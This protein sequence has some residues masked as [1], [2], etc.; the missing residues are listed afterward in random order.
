MWRCVAC[1]TTKRQQ[2]TKLAS[3]TV[4][5]NLVSFPRLFGFVGLGLGIAA[6]WAMVYLSSSGTGRSQDGE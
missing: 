6:V 1:Q 2:R 4:S 3:T 5:G